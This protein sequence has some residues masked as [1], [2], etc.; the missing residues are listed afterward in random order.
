MFCLRAVWRSTDLAGS[1]AVYCAA[2]F[3]GDDISPSVG[4]SA[5]GHLAGPLSGADGTAAGGGVEGEAGNVSEKM[6]DWI[7]QMPALRDA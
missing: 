6:P 3:D 4:E 1:G 2:A 5:V 7:V